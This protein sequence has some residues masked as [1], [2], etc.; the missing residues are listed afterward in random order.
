M[1]GMTPFKAWHGKKPT[2]KHLKTFG[3]LVYVRNTTLHLK[4]LEDHGRKMVFIGYEHGSKAY[5]A[6]DPV[7]KRVHVTRDLVFDER[8]QWDWELL[9]RPGNPVGAVMYSPSSTLSQ[10]R[11]PWLLK[12]GQ[13]KFRVKSKTWWRQRPVQMMMTWMQTTTMVCL[14]DSAAWT[15]SMGQ[16]HH[17][18]SHRKVHCAAAHECQYRVFWQQKNYMQ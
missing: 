5:R 3:C 6:Y 10:V 16:R 18:A 9:K 17:R 12:Q 1:D 4:K 14:S 11:R 8:A 13:I 2:V 15:T 7:T